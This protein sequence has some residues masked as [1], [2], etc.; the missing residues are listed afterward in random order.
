MEKFHNQQAIFLS[1]DTHIGRERKNFSG[2]WEHFKPYVK[3]IGHN[4]AIEA[5]WS[6]IGLLRSILKEHFFSKNNEKTFKI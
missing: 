5:L 3:E 1:N 4:Q 2:H 6:I